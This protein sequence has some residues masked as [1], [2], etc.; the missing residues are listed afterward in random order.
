MLALAPV[1]DLVRWSGEPAMLVRCN[2]GKHRGTAW[3]DVPADYLQWVLR[4]QMD[5]DV[6]FTARSELARRGSR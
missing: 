6:L 2:F 4:Q 1:F 5:E 3:R